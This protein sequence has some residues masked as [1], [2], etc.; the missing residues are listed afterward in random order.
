MDEFTHVSTYKCSYICTSTL[1]YVRVLLRMCECSYVSTS[2]LTRVRGL[3]RMCECSYVFTSALTYERGLSRMHECSYEDTSSLTYVR[4]CTSALTY[5]LYIVVAGKKPQRK[6][7]GQQSINHV[8]EV[9]RGN[10]GHGNYSIGSHHTGD[11]LGRDG[12][13]G[14]EDHEIGLK[15]PGKKGTP[16]LL[17]LLSIH[18]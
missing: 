9:T 16:C 6:N 2:A 17:F 10:P 1:T 7:K 5:V 3:V 12:A 15:R 8:C 13:R 14:I 18:T 4:V 11:V